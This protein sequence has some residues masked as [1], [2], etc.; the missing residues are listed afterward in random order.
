MIC[1]AQSNGE[2]ISANDDFYCEVFFVFEIFIERIYAIK[3]RRKLSRG[4]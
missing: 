3:K 4:K 1:I 2:A